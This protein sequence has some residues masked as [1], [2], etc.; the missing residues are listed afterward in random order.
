LCRKTVPTV[1]L[2][3]LAASMLVLAIKIQPV[4]ASVTVIIPSS[5]SIRAPVK[6]VVGLGYVLNIS[7]R[8]EN[9]GIYTETFNVTAY[10]ANGALTPEQWNQFWSMGDCN[11]DGYINQADLD[12]I[13]GS[14]GS[15][16]GDPQ[17]NP[18]ADINNDSI[19]DA[20]DLMVLAA[21]QGYEI[22]GYFLPAVGTQTVFNLTNGDSVSLMFTWNTT[23]LT[24]GNYSITAVAEPVTNE[25]N[26]ADSNYTSWIT[27]TIPGDIDGNFMVQPADLL[28]LS[29]AYGSK[30]GNSSWNPNADIDGN[31]VVGLTDLVLLAGHYEQHY[32]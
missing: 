2:V 20:L 21:H 27:V 26:T 16:P 12:I 19:V 31:D 7:A 28:V 13:N 6:T 29:H 10:Y 17:W 8:L 18:D 15:T 25:T 32:P 5:G 3:L 30:P 24:Y 9:Q 4:W 11:R 23:G 22:W 14:Y 1:M